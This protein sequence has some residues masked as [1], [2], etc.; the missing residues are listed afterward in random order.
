MTDDSVYDQ[1]VKQREEMSTADDMTG[2]VLDELANEHHPPDV[3]PHNIQP[4]RP[5][6]AAGVIAVATVAGLAR[7][8]LTV[9]LGLHAI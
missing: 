2:R 8:V 6:V 3:R 7:V 9:L 4:S 5:L 1:W